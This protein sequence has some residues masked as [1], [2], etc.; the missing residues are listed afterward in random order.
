MSLVNFGVTGSQQGVIQ[1]LKPY[2]TPNIQG[3]V[4][5]GG[6]PVVRAG[7]KNF[8]QIA[9]ATTIA[10]ANYR[11]VLNLY[12]SNPSA[13]ITATNFTSVIAG[14]KIYA[15]HLNSTD[16]CMYVVYK[17]NDG[18]IR[19]SKINDATGV[20]THIGSGFTPAT[21]AN[22]GYPANLEIISGDLR[23]TYNGKSHTLDKTTGAVV[24]QDNVFTLAGY[25]DIS[26]NYL[27][28]DNSTYS[29]GGFYIFPVNS[30]MADSMLQ[31]PRIANP[32][33]GIITEKYIREEL[34]LGTNLYG[35]GTVG[36]TLHLIHATLVDSDKI[37]FYVDVS[38]VGLPINVTLRS[39][40]D[41]FISSIVTYW[42]G[43]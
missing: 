6:I 17:G 9:P 28:L 36:G 26:A 4:P 31:A 7:N 27:S 25:A 41:S 15:L 33:T 19:L 18:L 5:V 10:D 34:I 2:P 32:V 13:L 21:P 40:Y 23:F 35:R 22:W 16:Q 39:S 38:G 12:N 43:L 24:T 29:S 37:C 11:T 30:A 42:S 20:V 1:R 3:A 8:F 14:A